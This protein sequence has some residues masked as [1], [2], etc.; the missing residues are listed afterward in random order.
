MN[1]FKLKILGSCLAVFALTSC[2]KEL[3]TFPFDRIELSQSFQSVKDAK[4]W[5]TGVYTFLKGRV[6]GTY[7]TAPEA[8][9]DMLNA[10]LEYGN[11]L[12]FFHRWVVQADDQ[13]VAPIWAGYYSG[14]N[15]AN[16]QING[17]ENITP[18][19]P[20]E[21]AELNRYKGDAYLARA[22]YYSELAR[23][24][25]KPYN[26]ATASTDLGLPLVLEYDVNNKPSRST[27]QQ[28]YDLILSDIAQAKS[29]LANVAGAQGSP[30]FT[31]DVVN[32]L[33]ARVRLDMEDFPGAKT[34]ADAVIA[35]GRYPLITDQA[36]FVN[37]W[38]NDGT[39]ESILQLATTK[40]LEL[41]NT[42]AIFL[43][44]IPA[45][46]RFNPD[47]IPS[48]WVVDSFPTNDIRKAAYFDLKDLSVQGINDD[49]VW[50]VNKYPGNPALWT[51][52]TTNYQHAPK[53]FRIAEMYLISA[54]AGARGNADAD[55]LVKLNALR[56]AR[57][58]AAL[59]GLS[60]DALFEAV[61]AERF[62]ELA[63]EGFRLWDL[64]RWEEPMIRHDPQNTGVIIVGPEF[65][66]LSI[67]AGDPRFVWP[68]PSRDVT[69]N[70][71]LI[72]NTGY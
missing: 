46:G 33:E 67:P 17:F 71:N 47:F 22:Y 32:A 19:T 31:I 41:A 45:T 9:S 50:L 21:T 3:E 7:L 60:D 39:R 68:I 53:V 44:F 59:S 10:A 35:T 25:T 6:Y 56:T 24:F 61:K 49:D 51:G 55:G 2:D 70:E 30:R 12:G 54:E 63:F 42:N 48:Q 15:N 38:H 14:I 62:R 64:K 36:D 20:A 58:L 5:N 8:Q 34:A 69:I 66:T 18:A 37:Y 40:P 57:G 11:R 4:T 52:A 28:T 65:T 29:L 72:Q 23:R 43:G 13:N 27:L 16:V 1:R 26:P